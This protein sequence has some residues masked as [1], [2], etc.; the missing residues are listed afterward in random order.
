MAPHFFDQHDSPSNL[1][2]PQYP[3]LQVLE[4]CAVLQHIYGPPS[5]Y[6]AGS[7]ALYGLTKPGSCLKGK[8]DITQVAHKLFFSPW[9]FAQPA[10]Q[11]PQERT[12]VVCS[13]DLPIGFPINNI[14]SLVC[15]NSEAL[16]RL[17]R[18]HFRNG[19]WNWSPTHIHVDKQ[20]KNTY[21]YFFL[22]FWIHTASA[23]ITFFFFC[24]FVCLLE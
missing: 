23:P 21:A 6:H 4:R 19:P 2:K 7:I 12:Q 14:I 1:A 18:G 24:L 16:K 9:C 22:W 5:E 8:T 17:A 11:L 10:L 3:R 15:S 20:K 13:D